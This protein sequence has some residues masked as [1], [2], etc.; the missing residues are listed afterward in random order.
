M[1]GFFLLILICWKV[2]RSLTLHLGFK[3][4]SNFVGKQFI[5]LLKRKNLQRFLCTFVILGALWG[6]I[7]TYLFISLTELGIS[8]QS[9]GISQSF[10]T[11]TGIFAIF[12]MLTQLL[13]CN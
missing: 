13:I 8:K 5:T 7:E 1:Q 10:A 3:K 12:K 9:L 2:S 11:M 4:K 6:L